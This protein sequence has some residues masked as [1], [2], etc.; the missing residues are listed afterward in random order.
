MML[1]PGLVVCDAVPPGHCESEK[2]APPLL[3]TS[4]RNKCVGHTGVLVGV[5]LGVE[6]RVIVGVLV[7]VGVM[8][9]VLVTVGVRDGVL[10]GVAVAGWP[11]H[12][13]K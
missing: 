2:A 12:C 8:V 5:L 7:V 10:L 3:A 4:K 1:Q 11:T 9:T 6:V 13:T